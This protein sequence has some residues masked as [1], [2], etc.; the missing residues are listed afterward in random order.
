MFEVDY[1][2]YRFYVTKVEERMIQSVRAERLIV[3][4]ENDTPCQQ[5]EKMIE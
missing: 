5:E 1:G 4:E 3:E 2:N